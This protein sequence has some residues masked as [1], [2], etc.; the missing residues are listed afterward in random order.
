MADDLVTPMKQVG[1]EEC[2]T[3]VSLEKIA[4]EECKSS[5]DGGGAAPSPPRAAE[6]VSVSARDGLKNHQEGLRVIVMT[7]S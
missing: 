6:P 5:S 4:F 2:K 7:S 1:I 3:P